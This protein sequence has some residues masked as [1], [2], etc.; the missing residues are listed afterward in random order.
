MIHALHGNFGLPSDWDAALPDGAPAK[1]WHLWEIR[2]HHPE[3]HTLTGFAT[4]FN[5]QIAALPDDPRRILA[6]YSLG[7][8]LALH[9]L[10][11]RP[12]LW[13]H[14]VILSTHPGLDSDA[15]RAERLEQDR[16]WLERCRGEAGAMDLTWGGQIVR[17]PR[18]VTPWS[19]V[20][21]AWQAQPVLQNPASGWDP[22]PL[23][24]WL[25]EIAQAFDGWS[26]GR[27]ENLLPSLATLTLNG[28]WLA[29]EED[30]KFCALARHATE[31]LPQFKQIII[32]G[33]GHRLPVHR[34]AEVKAV[35]AALLPN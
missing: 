20:C 28:S 8:R 29:G 1:A 3:A 13:Q 5:D 9:V 12:A 22:A 16:T 11:E 18:Q 30:L 17:P 27:Q 6:G 23:E 14:A 26:L 21:E 34:S 19:R 10:L 32:P 25:E 24:P 15:A 4:W 33:G 7:G 31:M 35:L 2:R